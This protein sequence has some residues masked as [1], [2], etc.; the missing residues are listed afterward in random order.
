MFKKVFSALLFV[1]LICCGCAQKNVKQPETLSVIKERGHIIVGVKTDTPPFGFLDKDGKNVGFDIDLAKVIAKKLF[2]DENKISFVPVDTTDRI[3]K[4]SSGEVDMIIATMSITPQRQMILD[5]SV[6]YHVA[7]EAIMVK[8]N[9]KI[10]SLLELK[11][12]TAIIVFGSTVERNL[13]SSVP[14]IKIIGYK[15]YPE[16]FA[17]LKE[18]KA[19]AMIADD[20]ILFG[21]ERQDNTVKILPKRYSREPYAIAFRKGELSASLKEFIDFEIVELVNKGNIRQLKAKWDID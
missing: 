14:N 1:S 12:K 3:K 21:F 5:F 11:D 6:P 20:T 18:G 16:A 10:S 7:G 2:N 19:D 17:A 8:K 4:L 13:R 15:T 9:S